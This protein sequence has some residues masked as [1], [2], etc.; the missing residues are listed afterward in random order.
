MKSLNARADRRGFGFQLQGRS[1]CHDNRVTLGRWV[2]ILHKPTHCS[3]SISPLTAGHTNIL[4]PHHCTCAATFSTETTLSSFT[5]NSTMSSK[6][7]GQ[8]INITLDILDASADLCPSYRSK[9]KTAP[10]L[11]WFWTIT[12]VF[13]R[14]DLVLR[15]ATDKM[16]WLRQNTNI[17]HTAD[18]FYTH[19]L[20]LF[21][22]PSN[23][24]SNKFGFVK[25]EDFCFFL[26][27]WLQ[28]V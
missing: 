9:T 21:V 5:T 25:F 24:S 28:Q 18:H 23:K 13:A 8:D 19:H 2:L 17:P 15:D 14:Q 4:L 6:A 10:F 27:A 1:R 11:I 16:F 7:R 12:T 26:N 3:N 22:P 20:Q